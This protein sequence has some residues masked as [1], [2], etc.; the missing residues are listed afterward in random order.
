MPIPW[1]AMALSMPIWWPSLEA[2]S[3]RDLESIPQVGDSVF[4][5]RE[6]W[7]TYPCDELAGK[8]WAATVR[9]KTRYTAVVSF[10]YNC[11]PDGTPYADERLDWMVLKGFV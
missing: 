7:P 9:S 2:P 1:D 8:G 10:D 6:C 5:P 4:V 11:A 3:L